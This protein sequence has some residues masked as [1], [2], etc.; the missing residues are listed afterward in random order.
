[1]EL[2]ERFHGEAKQERD[3]LWQRIAQLMQELER[4]V[5]ESGVPYCFFKADK[6]NLPYQLKLIEEQVS[7]I[8][9]VKSD[10]S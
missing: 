6:E 1:M 7:V 5:V 3:I 4:E 9:N 8:R 2:L 10:C